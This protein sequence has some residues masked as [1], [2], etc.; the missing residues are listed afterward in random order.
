MLQLEYYNET[1]TTLSGT[2]FEDLL[3][4]INTNFQKILSGK[5]DK[6]KTYYISMTIVDDKLIKKINKDYRGIDKPTDVVS[7][8]Y[9]DEESFPGQ[10]MIGEIFISLESARKQAKELGHDELTEL[11]F[12]FVHG[13]LHILGY[14]HTKEEDFQLMMDLTNQILSEKA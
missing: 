7:L 6:R 4:L 14:E 2:V 1:K 5:I 9:L 8:G 12:L 3:E 13:V 10:D 11:K